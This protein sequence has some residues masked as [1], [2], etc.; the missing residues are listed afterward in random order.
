LE[1]HC[2]CLEYLF[3]DGQH[4]G[5]AEAFCRE[6]RQANDQDRKKA[7]IVADPSNSEPASCSKNSE[8]VAHCLFP[9]CLFC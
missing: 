8:T 2:L 3:F 4:A 9:H 7:A 6:S 5:R 1:K